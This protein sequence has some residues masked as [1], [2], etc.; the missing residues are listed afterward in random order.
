MIFS[1]IKQKE[2]V[3][4]ID[5]ICEYCKCNKHPN[6]DCSSYSYVEKLECADK[7]A[8][9]EVND[10]K[11][12]NLEKYVKDCVSDSNKYSFEFVCS[13]NNTCNTCPLQPAGKLGINCVDMFDKWANEEVK[14]NTPN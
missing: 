8:Q 10:K 3:I 4:L 2:E 7:L 13:T 6:K 11:I 1:K 14:E 9:E 12:T 5:F